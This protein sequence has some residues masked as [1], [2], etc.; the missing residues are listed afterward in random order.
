MTKRT[1]LAPCFGHEVVR[2]GEAAGRARNCDWCAL[3]A[4]RH[5]GNEQAFRAM[6]CGERAEI[7]GMARL[8]PGRPLT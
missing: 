6:Q 5:K 7:V 1:D 4:L 8:K 2:L 3:R